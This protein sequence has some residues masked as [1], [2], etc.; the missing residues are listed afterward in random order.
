MREREIITM[1]RS[2]GDLPSK[3]FVFNC[4]WENTYIIS[5][6]EEKIESHHININWKNSCVYGDVPFPWEEKPNSKKLG[7][8][9]FCTLIQETNKNNNKNK[10]KEKVVAI[11]ESVSDDSI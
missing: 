2:M 11:S 7:N 5:N 9:S 8:P 3:T 10:N 6:N 4:F 1:I